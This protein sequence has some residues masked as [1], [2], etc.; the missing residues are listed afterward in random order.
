MKN[1]LY[2]LLTTLILWG[3]CNSC[4][5]Q[6]F[7]SLWDQKVETRSGSED[8]FIYIY[9]TLEGEGI[10]EVSSESLGI[11]PLVENTNLRVREGEVISFEAIGSNFNKW[12]HTDGTSK[13]LKLQIIARADYC[14]YT[15]FDVRLYLSIYG[16][17]VIKINGQEAQGPGDF[18]FTP[19]DSKFII[20]LPESIDYELITLVDQDGNLYL[21]GD[22]IPADHCVYLRAD[23]WENSCVLQINEIS[24]VDWGQYELILEG[25]ER[26]FNWN[27]FPFTYFGGMTQSEIHNNFLRGRGITGRLVNKGNKSFYVRTSFSEST[28]KYFLRSQEEIE[29]KFSSSDRIQDFLD[30]EI[31]VTYHKFN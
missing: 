12:E 3:L 9:F 5:N 7:D 26:E 15:Y 16:A 24:N 30:L 2:F 28:K 29:L 23:F 25:Y 21:H 11:M 10:V 22:E 13:D 17:G 4:E 8:E 27:I 20:D 14:V 1:K 18:E 19:R 31:Y 6:E